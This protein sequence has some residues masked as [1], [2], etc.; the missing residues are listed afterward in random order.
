MLV[1]AFVAHL[2]WKKDPSTSLLRRALL[3]LWLF[4]QP[5]LFGL[6]GAAVDVYSIDPQIIGVCVYV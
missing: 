6:I 4:V 1:V 5:F 3:M 2:Q